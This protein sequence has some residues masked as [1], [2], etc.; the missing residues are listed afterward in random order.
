MTTALLI[1][2]VQNDF[3][4]GGA[5][6]CAGGA[7]VAADIAHLVKWRGDAYETI[8][9][10]RDWHDADTDNG[11]HI[12]ATPDF[13][14]SW[15]PHCIAGTE[16]AE[17]HP[18]IPEGRIDLHVRKG[19]GVPAYS[20][21]E[22][23]LDDGRPLAEALRAEGVDR[24]DIVGIATDHCVRASALDALAAGFEVRVLAGLTAPVAAES[25]RI[26]LDELRAA[27]VEVAGADALEPD[28]V[29]LVDPVDP[30][31]RDTGRLDS[32]R[33]GSGGRDSGGRGS[34]GRD[35]GEAASG[36]AHLAE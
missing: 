28:R 8:A 35:S 15:P 10:S 36:G 1:V 17:Y 24:L 20:A 26:A 9:A 23:V 5:L 2:D 14:D 18:E 25:G 32:G 7:Q 3:T 33:R 16:G 30:D 19:M 4:E 11:G 21:F 34:G 31:R 27:G 22:G 29:E 13:V 6:A 12:S